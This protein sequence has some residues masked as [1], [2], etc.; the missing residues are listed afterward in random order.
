MRRR[1]TFDVAVSAVAVGADALALLGGF[2]LATWIRFASGW[3]PLAFE[4]RWP[5]RIA[6]T[7]DQPPPNLWFMYGWG[8]VIATLLLLFIFRSLGLFVRPQT[9]TFSGTVPRLFR[10]T[11]IG[12]LLAMALSFALRTAPP[13]SRLTVLIAFFVILVLL[14]L[15]R[16]VLFRLEIG[17]AKRLGAVNR[18]LIL[19]TGP[20]AVHLKSALQGE[21]R[22]RS[23]VA[24]FVRTTAPAATPDIPPDQ[25]VGSEEQLGDLIQ[26]HRIDQVIVADSSMDPARMTQIVMLCERNL[27]TFNMVPDLFHIMTAKVDVQ[28]VGNV[29]LLGVSRWPLDLFWNRVLKR[30]ED[31]AGALIGLVMGAPF[32]AVAAVIIRRTSPGPALYRQERCGEEGRRFTIYKLRTMRPDAEAETGPVWARE[33]D[34]RR[35]PFGAFIRRHNLDEL[36]QLWNVLK[37]EMSLVG[38]RPERPYFVEQFKEDISRYMWRHVSKPGMTGWA[39]V[40]GLRGNTGIEERINYDLYYLENWS[41]AFDFKILMRTFFSTRNAY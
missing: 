38:P 19:G 8:A 14:S 1:D 32:L 11:T 5:V 25:V 7:S 15:E 27:A 6:I 39:Q 20:V 4:V 29:P 2:L 22:L 35:T 34:P 23:E 16:F 40:N 18:V 33:D 30:A 9:G 37:G 10:A 13:F 26:R 17:L 3:I 24:G 28:M 31:V 41:L 21:P 12:L 36:P